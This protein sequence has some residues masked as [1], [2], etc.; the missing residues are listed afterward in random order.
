[1]A[2]AKKEGST[3]GW[4]EPAAPITGLDHLGS[5]A[6]CIAIY[7]ALLPGMTNVTDRARYYSFYPW[8]LWK[9][10]Q[11]G[12]PLESARF[13]ELYRRADCLFTLIAEQHSTSVDGDAE[14]HG[15]RM[16]GRDK[17]VPAVRDL[18][19]GGSL[20]LSDFA[21]EEDN[22]RR[23]FQNRLGGLG[24][25][26]VGT[27][28]ELGILA[29]RKGQFIQYDSVMGAEIAR[30]F[31]SGVPGDKFWEALR[32]DRVT[33]S[34][35][36]QLA[37][38]C[39]CQLS[40]NKKELAWLSKL[41]FGELQDD[42]AGGQRR[43][44]SLGLILHLAQEIESDADAI[45]DPMTFREACYTGSLPSGKSW[46]VPETLESIRHEWHLYQRNEQLSVCCQALL[47]L[48]VRSL[49][50]LTR[51]PLTATHIAEF[52]CGAAVLR[53]L[54][55]QRW[56][57]YVAARRQ[58]LPAVRDLADPNHELTLLQRLFELD[59]GGGG[60]PELGSGVECVL[61]ILAALVLR[62]DPDQ[63]SPY[64]VLPITDTFLEEYPINLRAFD[65]ATELWREL[66]VDKV[67]EWLMREW[68]CEVH[69]CIA[70]RKLRSERKDTFRFYPTDRGLKAREVPPFDLSNPR[71]RQAIQ[72]LRDLSTLEA[73]AQ[74]RLQITASGVKWLET[75]CRK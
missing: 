72:I 56:S 28:E 13:H 24:Q 73:D 63:Q 52:L 69:L 17:L 64:G 74:G 6:P 53:R 68:I 59:T 35:L 57:D 51:E 34:L 75:L 41:F 39:P 4:V 71:V 11:L 30:R 62:R 15:S 32:G 47:T 1:M 9:Y 26:Y 44:Q 37:S 36:R 58:L 16:V 45:L 14:R 43:R 27:L 70:L 55:R 19:G 10:S 38:F 25:Y 33:A 50:L 67:L 18:Q 12:E 49:E 3:V 60:L 54:G 61:Q 66:T 48:F 21:G 42:E 7:A 2:L 20:Q 5:A 29:G 40:T 23:Y 46:N 8:F 65:R 22:G 31:D